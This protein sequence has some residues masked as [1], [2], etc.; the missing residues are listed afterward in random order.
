MP[1]TRGTHRHWT[2]PQPTGGTWGTGSQFRD[3]HHDSGWR[4]SL[5]RLWKLLCFQGSSVIHA[6]LTSPPC[7]TDAPLG[8]SLTSSGTVLGGVTEAWVSMVANHLLRC[9]SE[10][11][12][13]RGEA[14]SWW[15]PLPAES[16]LVKSEQE[17][18]APILLV[19][20]T[21]GVEWAFEVLLGDSPGRW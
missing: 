11:T 7:P 2:Q 6:P 18:K 12:L 3:W 19:G 20:G 17:E 9:G 21:S 14:M 8:P 10:V 5:S 15:A 16:L 4:D 13:R 1:R